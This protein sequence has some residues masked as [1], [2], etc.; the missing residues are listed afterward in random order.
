MTKKKKKIGYIE[1]LG[2]ILKTECPYCKREFSFS[3]K[4][5]TYGFLYPESIKCKF[6]NNPI[7]LK[8]G[9]K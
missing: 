9:V 8:D 5:I 3:L 6:C 4:E 7:E 2:S 1:Y